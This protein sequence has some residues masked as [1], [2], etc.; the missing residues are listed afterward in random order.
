MSQ[1]SHTWTSTPLAEAMIESVDLQHGDRIVST[2]TPD[3]AAKNDL[4]MSPP[5]QDPVTMSQQT[6]NDL[7]SLITESIDDNYAKASLGSLSLTINSQTGYL[8]GTQLC[9]EYGKRLGEWKKTLGARSH[10]N[11]LSRQL[12]IPLKDLIKEV[13]DTRPN[14]RGVYV[15]GDLV[16]SLGLYCDPMFIVTLVSALSR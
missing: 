9:R 15:H 12:G 13:R 4:N 16:L 10:M 14:V 3:K 5:S 1:T 8:N 7:R 11:T 6:P 2:W